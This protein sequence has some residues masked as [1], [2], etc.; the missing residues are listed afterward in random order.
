M[1][2]LRIASPRS[3]LTTVC[4]DTFAATANF[5]VLKPNPALAIP[6]CIGSTLSTLNG[7][8][9]GCY[10]EMLA[11]RD[12]SGIPDGVREEPSQYRDHRAVS[13]QHRDQDLGTIT[14]QRSDRDQK[15]EGRIDLLRGF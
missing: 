7:T 13:G 10:I 5:L 12:G 14:G 9:K 3:N 4:G 11:E 8:T 1:V 6:H 2:R 15:T